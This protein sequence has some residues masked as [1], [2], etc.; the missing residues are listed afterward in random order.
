METTVVVDGEDGDKGFLELRNIK[1][2]LKLEN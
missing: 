2:A 1:N